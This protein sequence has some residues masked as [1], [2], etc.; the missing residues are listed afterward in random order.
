MP[1]PRPATSV[2]LVC[3]L[4]LAQWT[5]FAMVLCVSGSDH[6]RAEDISAGCCTQVAPRSAGTSLET[7]KSCIDCTDVPLHTAFSSDTSRQSVPDY[8]PATTAARSG[9][10]VPPAAGEESVDAGHPASKPSRSVTIAP[11]RC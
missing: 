5:G 6:A 7:S 8:A 11:L 4:L 2:L 3:L 9:D 10:L 1:Q